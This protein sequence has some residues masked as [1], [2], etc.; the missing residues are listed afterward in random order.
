MLPA[1]QRASPPLTLAPF[2]VCFSFFSQ[3]FGWFDE[4]AADE[5]WSFNTPAH[6]PWALWP[7]LGKPG[8][9]MAFASRLA[10]IAGTCQG[11]GCTPPPVFANS[12]V[13]LS[14]DDER[15]ARDLYWEVV[16][17]GAEKLGT[18]EQR[19]AAV[20]T[21]TRCSDLNPFIAEPHVMKAQL[22]MADGDFEAADAAAAAGFDLL[23]EWGGAWDKRVSWEAWLAWVRVIRQRAAE[24]EPWPENAL[25]VINL[26]LVK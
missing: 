14:E 18:P 20:A 25:G 22:L 5:Y 10:R 19:A 21:L 7:G 23:L 6:R 2:F 13:L 24:R 8:L 11:D 9:W 26:G 3:Y 4:L 12:T 1:A 15:A 17:V 16:T